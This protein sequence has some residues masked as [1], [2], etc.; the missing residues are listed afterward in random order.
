MA[1]TAPA[2]CADT[3]SGTVVDSHGVPVAGINIVAE[4]VSNGGDGNI[5]NAGTNAF[6][7]FNATIDPGTY[8]FTFQPPAPPLAV[9]LETTVPAVIVVGLT[10][11][12]TVALDPAVS[13]H[14]RL[15]QSTGQPVQFV[16][17]DVIVA[18][19]GEKLDIIG[20][21]SD[22]W[23]RSTWPWTGTPSRSPWSAASTPST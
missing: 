10:N 8:D 2:L 15:I 18:A 20:D 13:L 7:N 17:L 9:A 14:V 5:A 11:M 23:V 22:A 16:N 6:G 3:I 12:G 19:T 1:A 4:H 21:T